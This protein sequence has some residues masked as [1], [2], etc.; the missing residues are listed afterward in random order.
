MEEDGEGENTGTD[1]F[2]NTTE[3]TVTYIHSGKICL[4]RIGFIYHQLEPDEDFLLHKS[5]FVKQGHEENDDD[6]S[7]LQCRHYHVECCVN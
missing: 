2:E 7:I 3:Q 1:T 6:N 4:C 5:A